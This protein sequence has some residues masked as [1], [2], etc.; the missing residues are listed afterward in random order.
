M[1]ISHF[2]IHSIA[3]A[4][5]ESEI[6]TKYSTDELDVDGKLM[7]L[8]GELK[9]AYVGKAGKQYGVFDQDLSAC[10]VSSWLRESLDK[11]MTFS[12]FTKKATEHF[13]S[14]LADTDS[15]ID[16]HMVFL[17]EELAD[18]EFLSVYFL[19]HNEGSWVNSELTI[20]TCRFLDVR[21][22]LVGC[23][24]AITDWQ[25]ENPPSGYLSVLRARG[26]KDLTD[27]FWNWIGF[28]DKRDI[29]TETNQF[30]QVVSAFGE[31]LEETEAT[32]YKHKVIDYCLE[33]DKR[34]EPVIIRDLSSHIDDSEPK[35]F[36][37]FL[38]SAVG[39]PVV[40][41]IPDRGQIRQFVRISGRNDLLSLSFD[42][43]CVGESI[44]YDKEKDSITITN[45]PA[46]LKLR[47]L[48]YLQQGGP[49]K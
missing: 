4:T 23:R 45:I 17:Q 48:K 3:R 49:E 11:K 18:G 37:S 36:E 40:D 2:I 8:S 44:L 20:D 15:V 47:L 24:I 10:V 46:P 27:V 39:T 9:Q 21:G 29:A 33:Q 41:L 25:S 19:H 1:P 26:D 13:V 22:V 30:L 14:L 38:S 32:Q 5:T 6:Q 16:G 7:E 34:G 43:D 35:R 28:A 31:N 42:A 12:S